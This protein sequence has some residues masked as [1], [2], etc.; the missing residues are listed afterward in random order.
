MKFMLFPHTKVAIEKRY[1]EIILNALS[2]SNIRYKS[3]IIG[4]HLEII[5]ASKKFPDVK[6]ILENKKIEMLQMK[7]VGFLTK[8]R[9]FKRVGLLFGVA[10]IFFSVFFSSKIVWQI[11][12]EG[13]EHLTNSEIAEM[14]SSSGFYCG[15]FI[16]NV[17]YDKLHNEI[18]LKNKEISWVSINIDGNVANVLVKENETRYAESEY[19]SNIV[20]KSDAQILGIKVENGEQIVKISDVVKEGEILISGVIDSQSQGVRYEKAKGEIIARTSK[21][22]L[23][24]FP[25]LG[26]E[27]SYTGRVIK[28]NKIKIFSKVINIS[29]KSNKNL[30]FC[31]K[32]EENKQISIFGK[33]KLPIFI[34]NTKYFE[35]QIIDKEYTKR[36]AV[37]LAFKELKEKTDIAL[38]DAEL[39]SKFT[40]TSFDSDGFYIVCDLECIENIAKEVRIYKE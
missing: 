33:Y 24:N 37:D 34:E 40:Q 28:E 1:S 14:L 22:I 21:Q 8:L 27:K 26:K 38:M 35:Y 10:L 29:L 5:V 3:R 15:K 17:N 18:L 6:E 39:V 31:D 11:N 12:I 9:L 32:I 7:E 30:E 19:Y 4:E 25:Y 2:L 13:N 36:E 23:V 20:A 16:P